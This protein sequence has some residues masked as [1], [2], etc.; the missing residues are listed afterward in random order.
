MQH[1]DIPF[2]NWLYLVA[3]RNCETGFANRPELSA[4]LTGLRL[5]RPRGVLWA[6][7]VLSQK[8]AF[9]AATTH[10]ALSVHQSNLK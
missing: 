9:D 2:D 8:A 5:T 10:R 6:L 3:N 7:K 4:N 1:P